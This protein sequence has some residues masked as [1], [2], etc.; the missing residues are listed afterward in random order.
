[1]YS[2]MGWLEECM[3]KMMESEAAFEA[4][5]ATASTAYAT[6]LRS[7]GTWHAQSGDEFEAIQKYEEARGICEDRGR[8]AVG[9]P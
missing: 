7:M 8:T 2:K 3:A 4:A 9:P 5:Q 1:M 6:L